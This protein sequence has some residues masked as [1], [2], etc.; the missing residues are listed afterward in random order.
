MQSSIWNMELGKKKSKRSWWW[1]FWLFFMENEKNP[2]RPKQ[3]VVMWSTKD[4]DRFRINDV[5]WTRKKGIQKKG[6]RTEFGG[7]IGAWYYDGKEM[8]EPILL[9]KRDFAVEDKNGHGRLISCAHENYVLS[10]DPD[11]YN[12]SLAKK[13]LSVDLDMTS[14]NDIL[15]EHEYTT[16]DFFRGYGFDILKIRRMN[17]DGT[18]KNGPE[19]TRVKGTAYFQK[20]RISSPIIPSWYWGTMHTY[21]GSYLQYYMLHLGP[22]MFRRKRSQKSPWDWGEM[23]ITKSIS[24]YFKDE[25]KFYK[26]KDVRISKK[27][28]KKGMPVFRLVGKNGAQR[29]SMTLNSYSRACWYF[30]QPVLRFIK[31]LMYYNEYPV[32][33][34][35][36][37]LERKGRKIT[38]KDL[39]GGVGNSEHAW[40]CLR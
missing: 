13:G 37:S 21:D 25:D 35:R 15:S 28:T 18:I 3:M 8:I 10:G 7:A 30:E 1:W 38:E 19:E 24:F 34:S 22:P 20:V 17:L 4:C 39:I 6:N 40:G 14:T 2:A 31:T 5:W 32:R 29:I 9:D 16:N 26:F 27:Y 23:Y 33:L 11:H 36:F 12:L